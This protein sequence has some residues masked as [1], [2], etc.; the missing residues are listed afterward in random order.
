M[1]PSK[2]HLVWDW[3]GTLLDDLSLVVACTNAVFTREG[4]PTVTAEEHRVRFRRPIADYYAEVLGRAVD[5]EAFGRLDRIF[6]DAYRLGLTSCELAH[7]AVDAMAAWPGSQSLLS[8]WFHDELVPAIQTYGLTGRFARV[9]GLRASV[10]GDR[11]AESL[12]R[13]LAELGVDGRSVVLIGDSLDDADAA[14]A[15]GGRAVLYAG[16]FT[17]RAR[18]MASGHPVADTLTEAVTLATTLV[19]PA[20]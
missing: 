15:V 11:K 8:M 13:H 1:T 5:D 10:G 19:E 3:N 18:L 2:P 7:D 20:Q 17:D 4:G 16:G 6:H 12:V 14:R 9:D